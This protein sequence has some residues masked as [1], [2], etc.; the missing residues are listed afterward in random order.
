MFL[1]GSEIIRLLKEHPEV[2]TTNATVQSE[3]VF[4]E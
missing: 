1:A 2:G 4:E 3:P